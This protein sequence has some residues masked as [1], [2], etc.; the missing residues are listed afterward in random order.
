MF[1]ELQISILESF[2]K[3]HVTLKTLIMFIL[4]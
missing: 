3:V 2:R 1:V 4:W